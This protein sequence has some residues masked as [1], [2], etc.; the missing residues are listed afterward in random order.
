MLYRYEE[1]FLEKFLA[2]L[3]LRKIKIFPYDVPEFYDGIE[4]MKTVFFENI[5]SFGD[6]ADDLSLLFI[7]N[8][9]Q[10]VYS[11]FRDGISE[12]NGELVSFV[13]PEYVRCIV[14][15]ST[16]EAQYLISDNASLSIPENVMN[17][18]V[19]AFCNDMRKLEFE[20]ENIDIA[21]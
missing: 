4:R 16:M 11:R 19:S 12:L 14:K 20:K 2:E 1:D 5:D 21:V 17:S 9:Y 8:P 18:M 13:N 7:K 15:M 3:K 6:A 10:G